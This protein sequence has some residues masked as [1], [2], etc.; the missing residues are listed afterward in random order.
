MVTRCILRRFRVARFPNPPLP[1][2]TNFLIFRSA[3]MEFIGTDIA[4]SCFETKVFGL[5]MPEDLS[6]GWF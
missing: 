6:S 5:L 3:L 2:S 4:H 1:S